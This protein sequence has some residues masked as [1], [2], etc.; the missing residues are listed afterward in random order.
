MPA[1]PPHMTLGLAPDLLD[2]ARRVLAA[3]RLHGLTVPHP[4]IF[5]GGFLWDISV[6]SKGIAVYDP[7]QAAADLLRYLE[8]Q[9]LSG[10]LPNEVYFEDPGHREYLFGRHA[11]R[12]AGLTTSG[13]T[14]PP[15]IVR[16]AL[17][18]GRR[19]DG[20]ERRAFFEAVFPPLTKLCRWVLD[21]R[22]R[23]NGLAVSIHPYETGMDNRIDLARAMAATWHGEH[24]PL[25]ARAKRAAFTALAAAVR[26]AWGDSRS[27]PP[28]Q[29]SSHEDVL[30]AFLQ[31]RH[32]RSLGYD[33]DAVER[34]G[35]GFLV[36]DVGYNAVLVDAFRCLRELAQELDRPHDPQLSVDAALNEAM[37]RVSVSLEGL[38]HEDPA[39][40][41]RGYFSR[42]HRTGT[43]LLQPTVAGLFPLLVATDPHRVEAMTQALTDPAKYWT[44]VAPPS[45][46][47]DSADFTPNRYWQGPAWS[48]PTDIL[49]TALSVQGLDDVAGE[50]RCRYLRRPHGDQHA[51][52]EN[53]LTGEPLGVRSFSPAAAL[54]IRFADVERTSAAI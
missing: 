35:Q 16:A 49:E 42:D 11:D 39:G 1:Y 29:R 22:V 28:E 10:M 9:W 21:R 25:R 18:V 13:I 32:L 26:R 15:M 50:L 44:P 14:Q 54:A 48:F 34:S 17:E 5:P 12:P 51:E 41:T 31:T 27:V 47:L 8:S 38:W 3:N 36:E 20:E 24:Q 37:T 40:G 33:L 2:G 30:N 52:Y 4:R 53:P 6:I 45:A 23:G 43:L 46:P 19:L 7:R